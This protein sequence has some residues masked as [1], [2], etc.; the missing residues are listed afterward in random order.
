M[1][2]ALLGLLGLGLWRSRAT[3]DTGDPTE[4]VRG[5]ELVPEAGVF[6]GA[7]PSLS[8]GLCVWQVSED[9]LQPAI[10]DALAT[11]ARFHRVLVVA[12]TGL[13]IPSVPGGPVY[14][15]TTRRPGTVGELMALVVR[16]GRWWMLP[17]IVVLVSLAGIMLTLQAVQYVAP[18]IY[19]VF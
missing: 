18:F 6:G 1:G 5:V 10:H 4:P 16:G 3:A 17:L 19:M 15:S 8:D 7:T 12:P 2:A 14:L 11:L 9:D 13:D